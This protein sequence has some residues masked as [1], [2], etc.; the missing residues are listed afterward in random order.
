MLFDESTKMWS[1]CDA[2]GS[3]FEADGGRIEVHKE[4][5]GQEAD[6]RVCTEV[7]QTHSRARHCIPEVGQP[8]K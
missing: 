5:G 7:A 2:F 1:I 6:S 4:R 8:R 3:K